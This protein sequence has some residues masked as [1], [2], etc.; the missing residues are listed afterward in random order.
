MDLTGP[1]GLVGLNHE[2]R[3]TDQLILDLVALSDSL[4][5]KMKT[6]EKAFRKTDREKLISILNNSEIN[7]EVISNTIGVEAEFYYELLELISKHDALALKL[8]SVKEI[9]RTNFRF[10]SS[11]DI[12]SSILDI[13]DRS[14]TDTCFSQNDASFLFRSLS[15][16]I[17]EE[18]GGFWDVECGW[19]ATACT[20]VAGGAST[21]CG[22]WAPACFLAGAALC[23]CDIAPE[24]G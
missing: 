3:T 10:K 17:E 23:F 16:E 19:R 15:D 18:A 2:E 11:S 22:P 8:I 13:Y 5:P 1:N 24:I 4:Y 20:V 21:N 14:R 9:D 12:Y 7:V 6:F